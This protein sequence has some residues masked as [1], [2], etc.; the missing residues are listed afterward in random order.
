MLTAWLF[1]FTGWVCILLFSC[2]SGEEKI[3]LPRATDSSAKWPHLPLA[4]QT[5]KRTTRQ[6][7]SHSAL[8]TSL[9]PPPELTNFWKNRKNCA[10]FFLKGRFMRDTCLQQIHWKAQENRQHTCPGENSGFSVS[11]WPELVNSWTSA[12]CTLL[13]RSGLCCDHINSSHCCLKDLDILTQK[14]RHKKCDPEKHEFV[15][16]RGWVIHSTFLPC[17]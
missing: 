13:L 14:D 2:S 5:L 7:H 11:P 16:V 10:L 9:V 1:I 15:E 17:S 12:P 4:A 3:Y 8:G 6:D